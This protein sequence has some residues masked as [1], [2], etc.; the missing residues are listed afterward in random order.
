VIRDRRDGLVAARFESLP[1][2]RV[3]ALVSTRCGGYSAAPYA[4]LNL[5]LRVEDDDAT[6]V[7]NRELLFST[8]ELELDRSVWC[9][10]V[11]ADRVTVVGAGDLGRGA[12]SEVDV[13]A[14][15]DA[16][17]TDLVDVPLVVTIADCVPI[18]VYDP[19]NH[20]VGL[21]HAGWRGTV[22]RI[23]S[24]TVEV[25]RERFG[26][27]PSDV[28][29]AIGPSIA[30]ADY[31]V[32]GDVIVQA[33]DAFG[34]GAERILRMLPAGKAQFDLWEA[35]V[36]DLEHAG[37]PRAQIEVAAVSTAAA[38]DEF[39]SYRAEG[40]TGRFATIVALGNRSSRQSTA[41]RG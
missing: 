19:R 6:V 37:V 41:R 15:T 20:V 33:A 29:A 21:A 23:G 14:E 39:Y 4:G 18:V 13:V 16:L 2:E 30:A 35:N 17:V 12:R 26:T 11:H 40:V 22:R 24:R 3:D 38:L 7:R 1:A 36:Q 32:G 10:Q 28:M 8:Y 25:M 27:D 34:A 5:G 9:R 31:E